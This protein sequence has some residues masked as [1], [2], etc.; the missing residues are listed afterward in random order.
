M[1]PSNLLIVGTMA[2]DALETPFGKE[3]SVFGGSASYAAYAASFFCAPRI[4]SIVG[5]DFPDEYRKILEDKGIDLSHVEV[6]EG[7][8]FRW[9]G[10]YGADLNVAETLE[11][12]INVLRDLHPHWNG[13]NTPENLFL[14]NVDPEVQLELLNQL[15]RPRMKLVA[16]DTMNFWIQGRR[17]ALEKVLARI[18]LL[19]LNDGEARL[20]TGET[21]LVRAA[22]KIQEKGPAMVV[23]KKGEHGVMLFYGQQFFVVPAYPLEDVFDPTGAGDTF[24][25]A[26]IGYL[27]KQQDYTFESLCRAVTYGSIIASFTVERFGLERL[28]T[29]T[30]PEIEDRLKR[31]IQICR[32]PL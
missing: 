12:Q 25:G 5:H 29:L 19:V 9:R 31:F 6:R 15:E 28:T 13:K 3:E 4:V 11:T 2:I 23:I 14:A 18:D 32:M 21:S 20:L 26:L 30:L 22:R 24:G 1:N 10:R 7:K 27:A 16:A 8:T 17:P